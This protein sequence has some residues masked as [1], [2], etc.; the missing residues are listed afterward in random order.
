MSNLLGF[1][2]L[3]TILYIVLMWTYM[4]FYMVY[5]DRTTPKAKPATS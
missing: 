4:C 5:E 3:N 1:Y 2:G